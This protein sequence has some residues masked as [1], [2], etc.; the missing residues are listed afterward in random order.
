E[1]VRHLVEIVYVRFLHGRSGDGNL[2]E[3]APRKLLYLPS[4][5]ALD[6]VGLRRLLDLRLVTRNAGEE[7]RDGALEC[8]ADP[9]Y[10][11]RLHAHLGPFLDL[12]EVPPLFEPK[13]EG[14]LLVAPR[15]IEIGEIGFQ[16]L[17]KE[18]DGAAFPDAVLADKG[19]S[20]FHR[21]REAIYPERVYT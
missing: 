9:V 12:R 18:L 15:F 16:L 14:Y 8:L 11:L 7:L 2:L 4:K 17:C 6:A 5:Y 10:L 3:L 21:K 19:D 13:P 20:P 1:I